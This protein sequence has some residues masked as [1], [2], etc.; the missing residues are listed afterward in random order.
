MDVQI[1]PAPT[2]GP[3]EEELRIEHL[4]PRRGTWE[5][6]YRTHPAIPGE[7]RI[8]RYR[9]HTGLLVVSGM[10]LVKQHDGGV[11]PEWGL[12]VSYRQGRAN[13][14]QV[15][16]ALKLFDAEEAEEDNHNPAR[17]RN[18][19]M[20]VRE[21]LRRRECH[22]KDELTIVE[23]D[24]YEWQPNFEDRDLPIIRTE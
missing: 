2:A 22:C 19:W 6:D 17:A 14:R 23:P 12:S 15:R 13:E 1:T 24:G 10:H 4:K 16:R 8:H 7:N 21:D 18:F 3:I 20:P 9:H 5:Y 11:E